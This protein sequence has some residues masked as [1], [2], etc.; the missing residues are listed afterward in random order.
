MFQ[1]INYKDLFTSNEIVAYLRKSRSDDALLTVEEVLEKHETMLDEWAEKNLDGKVP[2]ENK[3]FEVVSG[4]TIADRPEFQKVLRLIESPKV[5]AILCYDVSRLSRGD[6]EDAGRLIKLL[7]YTNT[8]V[9]TLQKVYD[10]RDEYDRDI[11]ERELKRGNEYLEYFKRISNNGR[12]LSVKNGNFIAG[13]IPYGYDR[14]I[15]MDGKRKCPTLTPNEEQ[16]E[17][18]R[19]IFDMYVNQDLGMHSIAKKL[20]ELKIPPV[21]NEYWSREVIRIILDNVHYI[22]KVRW[23]DRKTVNIV[24]DGEIKKR[25]RKSAENEAIIC[26]GKHPAIIDEAIFRAAQEKRGR[27]HRAKTSTKLK[28]PLAGIVYCRCGHVM[29]YRQY[30][31]NK[32]A[33]L[34]CNMKSHCHTRSCSFDAMMNIVRDTLMNSIEDFEISIKKD[35]KTA[36][37]FR[38]NQIER[39][40]L[41]I[42]ELSHKEIVQWEQYTE[43]K[44]PQ[45]IFDVLNEKVK[46]EIVDAQIALDKAIADNPTPIDYADKIKRFSD[47]IEALTDDSID[48]ETK[49]VLL[50]SC[51]RRITYSPGEPDGTYSG[52]WKNLKINADIEL[53]V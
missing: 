27:R 30:R 3:Y 16:A 18:V 43:G 37:T 53:M 23:Q 42:D 29:I 5:K 31:S 45:K 13:Q 36:R 17:V 14:A 21:R 19:T 33:I 47:A 46:A 38:E 49:N 8:Y 35:D 15:V 40:K 34:C 50:K 51:I 1:Y 28:N 25:V 26:D 2:S 10:V 6:L 12:L 44:M 32:P 41:R 39:L 22:G 24:E 9:I 11:F 52:R 48:A 4:E 20:D 7:R